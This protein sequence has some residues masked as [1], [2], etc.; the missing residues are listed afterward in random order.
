MYLKFNAEEIYCNFS[1]NCFYA[2]DP[3]T[4]KAKLIV[5]VK[6]IHGRKTY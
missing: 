1:G 3:A 2:M 5:G 6:L 4:E